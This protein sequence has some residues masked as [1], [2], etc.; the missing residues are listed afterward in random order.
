MERTLGIA[1]AALLA[2]AMLLSALAQAQA[3]PSTKAPVMPRAD[4]ADPKACTDRK[5]TVGQGDRAQRSD[6]KSLSDR[7]ARS[8]GVICPP[9]QVDPDIRQPPPSNGGAMPVIPPPGSPGGD[10]SVQPK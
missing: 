5:D 6:D 1:S 10:P 7:L 2:I 9:Q 3:P 4:Q 8:D